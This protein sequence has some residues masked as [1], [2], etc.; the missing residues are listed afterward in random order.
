MLINLL[1]STG[2]IWSW[3]YR[4]GSLG[5]KF[6]DYRWFL[7]LTTPLFVCLPFL[8][9][10]GLPDVW[11]QA[12]LSELEPFHFL[13]LTFAFFYAAQADGFG[14]NMDLGDDPKPDNETLY[15]V[16]DWFFKEK[17]S[18]NRDL[19][20]LFMRFGLQFLPAT[21]AGF[22]A[23][24]GLGFACLFMM[25]GP[26][27]IWVAEKKFIKGT[28]LWGKKLPWSDEQEIAWVEWSIGICLFAIVSMGVLL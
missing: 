19:T 20:G 4:G 11:F 14:R 27:L 3:A 8:S 1:I 6:L 26:P 9:T 25:F 13:I 2:L 22:Y 28:K 18:F 16:R 7:L 24:P 21:I 10:V 15:W 5:V 23:T 17:S 12:D